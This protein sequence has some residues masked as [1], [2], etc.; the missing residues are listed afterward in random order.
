MLAISTGAAAISGPLQAQALL[1]Q[2]VEG[3]VERSWL[4]VTPVVG[5]DQRGLEGWAGLVG[6]AGTPMRRLRTT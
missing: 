6:L 3:E 2:P 1:P 4:M 5:L